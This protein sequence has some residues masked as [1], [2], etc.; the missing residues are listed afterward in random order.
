MYRMYYFGA[1][2]GR[3]VYEPSAARTRFFPDISQSMGVYIR[4]LSFSG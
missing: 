1:M 3:T 2:A 4:T